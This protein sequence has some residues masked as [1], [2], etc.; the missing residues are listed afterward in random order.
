M[1]PTITI[2]GID[3]GHESMVKITCKRQKTYIHITD[4]PIAQVWSVS[5]K[6]GISSTSLIQE[7]TRVL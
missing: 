1:P 3:Q 5:D 4:V 7:V 6:T 2:V